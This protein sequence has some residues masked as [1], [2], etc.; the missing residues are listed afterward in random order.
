MCGAIMWRTILFIPL[1]ACSSSSATVPPD[2]SGADSGSGSDSGTDDIGTVVP[3]TF[4]AINTAGANDYPPLPIGTAGHPSTLVWQNVQPTDATHFDYRLIDMLVAAAPKGTDGVAEIVLTLGR[5]PAWAVADKTN[6]PK[7]KQGLVVSCTVPPDDP[8]VWS[9]FV[10]NLAA[11]FN[12][13]TAPRVRYYEIWNEADT[14]GFWTGTPAQLVALAQVA[15]PML[16]G[17]STMV[18]APSVVGDLRTPTSTAAAWLAQYLAAG[19]SMYADGGG[20]HGYVGA[21]ATENVPNYPLPENEPTPQQCATMP[22]LCHGTIV[23]QVA[24]VRAVL[25]AGGLAAKPMFDTEG[26]WGVTSHVPASDTQIAWITHYFILQ[27]SL[28]ATNQI[29]HASWFAWGGGSAQEW[30]TIEDDAR[31]PTAAGQ[32]YAVVHDWL[33]GAAVSPCS[34]DGNGVWTCAIARTGGYRALIAW[35]DTPASYSYDAAYTKARDVTGAMTTL[36]GT[37]LALTA[38]PVLF[39]R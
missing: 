25:D 21:A 22:A 20:F 18:L 15:Y 11:H 33:V 27:A 38:S 39:E 28:A 1:V 31:Q 2:T 32:A 14:P 7:N 19:G 35:S 17:G 34:A 6:C 8:A 3:A 9:A 36:D 4:F 37:P 5:T 13:V 12:G 16:H 10:A 30:G 24:T 23:E 26:G 29:G